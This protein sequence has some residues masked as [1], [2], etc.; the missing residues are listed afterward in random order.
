MY[1]DDLDSIFSGKVAT[2]KYSKSSFMTPPAANPRL[3]RQRDS[4]GDESLPKR[5]IE[6]LENDDD[7]NDSVESNSEN[8]NPARNAPR[9]AESMKRVVKRVPVR[10]LCAK[11][12]SEITG[13]LG[14][15]VD[16]QEK[17]VMHNM[18]D[19]KL[20]QALKIFTLKYS[21][22]LTVLNR[23]KFKKML[24]A[25]LATSEMFLQLDDVVRIGKHT[26]AD[27]N[28]L[29][30]LLQN[31][32]GSTATYFKE[33]LV[34]FTT[35]MTEFEYAQARSSAEQDRLQFLHDAFINDPRP[36]IKAYFMSCHSNMLT[37]HQTLERSVLY[38]EYAL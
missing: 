31:F 35:L 9:A 10:A 8:M 36:N 4:S 18:A 15:I 20:D 29:R 21:S 6:I 1:F 17:I 19:S 28:R 16:N 12:G 7:D 25:Q 13:F 38:F 22:T 37:Y 27:I 26:E 11:P 32:K 5:D 30:R 33:D 23:L 14:E 24:S 2:G 3:K 34:K